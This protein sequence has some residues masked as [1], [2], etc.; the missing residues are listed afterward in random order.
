[1]TATL[2][3]LLKEVR[4]NASSVHSNL[5]GEED[6]HLGFVCTPEV[7]QELVPN[8]EEFIRPENPGHLQFEQGLTQYAIAQARDEYAEA[9]R[10]FREVISV[11]QA[12]GQQLVTAIGQKNISE[13]Y[14]PQGPTSSPKQF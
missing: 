5:G 11:E 2:I 13:L 8:T 7:Y 10:V 9:T 14:V 1:M 3:V 6:G 12:I 4:A